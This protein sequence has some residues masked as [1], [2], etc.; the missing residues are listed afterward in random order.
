MGH[1][2]PQRPV[3]NDTSSPLQVLR[4]PLNTLFRNERGLRAGWRL[5]MYVAMIAIFSMVLNLVLGK[6]FQLPK[7]SPPAPWQM[8]LQEFLSLMLVFLP[9]FLM[10]RLEHRP[11]GDYGLPLHSLFGKRFWQGCA[12]GMAEVAALM[13]CI[14]A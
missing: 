13:G 8:F 2:A 7:I 10:A 1:D 11:V 12:L 3:H 14:A 6:I 9:A 5:L 4:S